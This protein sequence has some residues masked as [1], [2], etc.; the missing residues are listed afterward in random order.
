MSDGTIG[1]Q[2]RLASRVAGVIATLGGLVLGYFFLLRPL[3]QAQAH[4]AEV[5]GSSKW[6]FI[7]PGLVIL[8]I[9]AILFP[10][11]FDIFESPKVRKP[12]GSFTGFGIVL[13]LAIFVPLIAICFLVNNYVDGQIRQ[14]GYTDQ[15]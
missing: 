3:Q 11:V 15:P 9:G 14:L 12:N 13:V 5:S 6:G 8:G 7:A 4:A 10:G 2:S 1:G